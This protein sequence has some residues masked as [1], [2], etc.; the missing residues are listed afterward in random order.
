MKRDVK[1]TRFAKR[2]V[3][4]S[5]ED[6]KVTA[7]RVAE[8]LSALKAS[9]PRHHLPI[10]KTYLRHIRVAVARQTAMV[11]TA[12]EL[13]DSLLRTIEDLFSK[14][15]GRSI[16]SSTS[17]DPSLIAGLRVRVGDDVYDATVAGRLRRLAEGVR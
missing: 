4:L 12:V 5:K 8:V 3:E 17:I 7:D 9:P 6:G 13:P 1:I 10:L 15:Y 11:G 2:L 14:T 16:E